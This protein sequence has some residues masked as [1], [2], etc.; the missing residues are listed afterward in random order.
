MH[1]VDIS[2]SCRRNATMTRS[3]AD[4]AKRV[5][6]LFSQFSGPDMPGAVVAVTEN[7]RE[8]FANAYGL[9]NINNDIPMG[10]KTIIRI[11]SQSKQFTVLL[12]LMLEAEGKL[13]MDDEVQ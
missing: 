1:S 8:I 2:E 4:F 7:G 12:T 5:D 6:A 11:G 13:S 9:A 10:R 3:H